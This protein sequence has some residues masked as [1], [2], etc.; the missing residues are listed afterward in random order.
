M[1]KRYTKQENLFLIENYC[2]NGAKYCAQKLNRTI[3]AIKLHAFY[4]NLKMSST[5]LSNQMIMAHNPTDKIYN[6]NP[7]LFISEFIPES[8]YIL[9]LIWADGCLSNAGTSQSIRL[10]M[11]KDDC[12]DVLP[13]FLKTGNWKYYTY[14]TKWKPLTIIQTNNRPI[15]EFLISHN[16]RSKDQS[17]CSILNQIPKNLHS[18]W[19][20]GLFDGDGCI[21]IKGSSHQLSI[22][23]PTN[24]DWQYLQ[25]LLK[26][27]NVKYQVHK[28]AHGSVI[29]TTNKKDCIK[30]RDY[31]YAGEQFG[32]KRKYNK[33]NL[34]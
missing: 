11:I 21:Y 32:L 15:Y 31:I 10:S 7:K 6:V 1:K 16:Y 30:F 12:N 3:I 28:Q 22:S 29:R 14:Q 9:G 33:L 26:N 17:A 4:L 19:F 20:R 24:Q 18:Y 13:I 25:T 8:T 27:L 34:L 5:Q 23:G 2:K